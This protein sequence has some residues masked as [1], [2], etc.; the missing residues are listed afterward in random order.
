MTGVQKVSLFAPR[1]QL[2]VIPALEFPTGSFWCWSPAET[3]S[4][5]C[6]LP[7]PYATSLL[8]L[9]ALNKSLVQ[10]SLSLA[11]LPGNLIKDTYFIHMF[12]RNRSLSPRQDTFGETQRWDE[13]QLDRTLGQIW[14]YNPPQFI[15]FLGWCLISALLLILTDHI[16][17]NLKWRFIYSYSKVTFLLLQN[18]NYYTY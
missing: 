16:L 2:C 5:L 11:L 6:F 18:M 15:T 3:M 9:H 4:W 7:L 1:D 13:E 12:I 14:T 10:G 17:S 8:P